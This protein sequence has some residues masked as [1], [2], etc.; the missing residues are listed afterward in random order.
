VLITDYVNYLRCTI[1]GNIWNV[2]K[3]GVEPFGDAMV[4][5]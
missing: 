2:P 3:P 4:G 5:I 1:C